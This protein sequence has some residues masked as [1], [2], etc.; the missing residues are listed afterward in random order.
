VAERKSP[1]VVYART[2]FLMRRADNVLDALEKRDKDRLYQ[3]FDGLDEQHIL[4]LTACVK[5]R[6][7]DR[8]ITVKRL[9][10]NGRELMSELQRYIDE[11]GY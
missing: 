7:R 8:G 2:P 3:F 11:A 9:D 1:E 6:A 4:G 5:F 10:Y